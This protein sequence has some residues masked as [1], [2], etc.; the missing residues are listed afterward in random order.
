VRRADRLYALVDELRVRSPRPASRS[1]L[2]AALEVSP[3]T[4]ER[5]ICALQVAGVP[6]WA[7]R[8]RAGG[9]V[10]ER[11]WHL[12]PLNLDA[13]EA[14]GLLTA[15]ARAEALPF[16]ASAGRAARKTMAGL[17][18]IDSAKLALLAQRVFVEPAVTRRIDPEVG[19]VI[20]AAVLDRKVVRL[21]YLDRDGRLS[22]RDVE[23]HG[24]RLAPDGAYLIGWCRVRGGARSFR[25]D[26]IGSARLTAET[27]P[28]RDVDLVRGWLGEAGPLTAE[29]E[30]M[31]DPSSRNRGG[32][33]RRSDDQTGVSAAFVA[34]VIRSLPGVASKAAQDA[35]VFK[36]AD[37]VFATV[38]ANDAG[39]LRLG[40]DPTEPFRVRWPNLHRDEARALIQQAW[41]KAAPGRLRASRQRA[42]AAVP[43]SLTVDD[44]RQIVTA[45]PAVEE[46]TRT[47]RGGTHIEWQTSRT[48]FLMHGRASNLLPP[49]VDDTLMIRSCP[50]RPSLLSAAPDRYFI[51][52][53]YGSSAES[54]PV[55]TRLAEN[56]TDHIDELAELIEESWRSLAPKRVLAA[57][58]RGDNS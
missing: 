28:E 18:P 36:V 50:D 57:Y 9:Y 29:D 25:F 21:Q 1:A 27:A 56:T 38:E 12:P 34:A 41:T 11:G 20:E 42:L 48:M 3:R 24:I 13:S 6:I 30:A 53:H 37:T 55:L 26:R 8:G 40:D 17:R 39:T 54:G 31:S 33:P 47:L 4:I 52:S 23:A 15:L 7:E 35:T 49:D 2:A 16:A 10:L 32:P 45:L 22:S 51:T 44:I 46:L 14:L 19:S 43:R 5:D 58:D